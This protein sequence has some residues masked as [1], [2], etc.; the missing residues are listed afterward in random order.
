MFDKCGMFRRNRYQVDL[1]DLVLTDYDGRGKGGTAMTVGYA[2]RQGR[3]LC[4]MAFEALHEIIQEQAE[5]E[6]IW[7][8]FINTVFSP[9]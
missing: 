6:G 4:R 7:R 8:I 2:H 9:L 1:C 5:K 3:K